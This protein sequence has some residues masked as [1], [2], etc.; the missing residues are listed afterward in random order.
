MSV[1]NVND[2][3]RRINGIIEDIKKLAPKVDLYAANTALALIVRRIF[4][5]GLAADGSLI[6]TYDNERKQ[7]FLTKKATPSL[8]KK[9]RAILAKKRLKIGKNNQEDFT[10]L[11]YK[12]LRELK[13]LQ[14]EFVDLQFTGQLFES[15]Q[16]VNQNDKAIVAI[17]NQDRAKVA[18]YLEKKYDKAIFSLAKEERL[19][20]M[21]KTA[22]F[23]QKEVQKIIQR[24]SK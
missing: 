2:A 20:V 19:Q 3:I 1:K 16:V 9:Q 11:T 22:T 8:T 13:G 10:G 17:T 12:E 24:W 14:V 5:D 6:G 4:N 7:K 21:E 23:A 18:D 15:I